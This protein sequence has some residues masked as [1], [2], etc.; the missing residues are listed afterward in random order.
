MPIRLIWGAW[1]GLLGKCENKVK[2]ME[3]KISK[4]MALLVLLVFFAS[5]FAV[6]TP[7]SAASSRVSPDIYPSEVAVETANQT[8]AMGTQIGVKVVAFCA[9]N[10]TA[11]CTGVT[12]SGVASPA[13]GG[14]N[15]TLAAQNFANVT[16][17]TSST[18]YYLWNSSTVAPLP[19]V[20]YNLNMTVNCSGDT[21]VTNNTMAATG[22]VTWKVPK[23]NITAFTT[24]A[25]V[26]IGD[27]LYFNLT[28]KN[29]GSAPFK[30]VGTVKY[31]FTADATYLTADYNATTTNLAP[32][33]T[34]QFVLNLT[35]TGK[36][37][38]NAT[39]S[40]K[41][42]TFMA[43]DA[44]STNVTLVAKTPTLAVVTFVATPTTVKATET[45]NL[46]AT[47]SNTGTAGATGAKVVFKAE[48]AGVE[49]V[50][51]DTQTVDVPVGWSNVTAYYLWVPTVMGDYN[52][53][54]AILDGTTEHDN[55]T[56]AAVISMAPHTALGISG[57]AL[58]TTLETLDSPDDNQTVGID[59][60]VINNGDLDAVG[61]SVKLEVSVGGAANVTVGTNTVDVLL[62]AT[63]TTKF[64]YNALTE[65]DDV[66]IVFYATATKGTD[67][68]T[69][70]KSI[71]LPGDIDESNVQ[72]TDLSSDQ[73]F[74]GTTSAEAGY[75]IIFT[76]T[77]ENLGDADA[78][79]VTFTWMKD[80]VTFTG[81]NATQT[82]DLGQGNMTTFEYT[83]EI[84]KTEALGMKNISASVQDSE[85]VLEVEVT[86]FL[87]PVVTLSFTTNATSGTGA[88]TVKVGYKLE[89]TGS[90]AALLVCVVIKDK[91]SGKEVWNNSCLDIVMAHGST[92]GEASIVVPAGT[93]YTLEGTATY[94]FGGV[95]QPA[96]TS[97][98]TL[99]AEA[100]TK[101]KTSPGFEVVLIVAALAIALMVVGRKRRN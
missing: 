70:D 78:T 80:T 99:V 20:A 97:G 83:W 53:T 76:A 38:G 8:P 1:N 63:N 60:T 87:M 82:F 45:M 2:T 3:N 74:I 101:K 16:N 85:M 79:G 81:T 44:T 19:D 91:T 13:L 51:Q 18:H 77:L 66:T 86:E 100:K 48:L 55:T 42:D 71:V 65:E 14:T 67:V 6:V 12:I 89:N 11:N 33:G 50:L 34:V 72:V 62:G 9:A 58:P 61:V 29:E 84:P 47:F 35:T 52:V 21:N 43:T 69:K 23:L 95:D 73:T 28:I 25:T 5:I 92:T 26:L 41:V 39:I 68:A 22:T 31:K 75:P 17:G 7:V 10:A 88:Q 54:V 49:T 15:I 98:T 40:A 37:A 96:V 57:I 24:P 46:T 30:S 56:V 93:T 94:A 64:T 32:A 27:L 36:T 59:V 4:T 90:A